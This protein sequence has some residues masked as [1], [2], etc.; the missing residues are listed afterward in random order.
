MKVLLALAMGFHLTMGNLALVGFA[1]TVPT[2]RAR[3]IETTAAIMTSLSSEN[4]PMST[5]MTPALPTIPEIQSVQKRQEGES[6]LAC[7]DVQ[8]SAMQAL[9][10]RST[11]PTD[12][13]I[14]TQ[15]DGGPP[16]ET[17]LAFRSPTAP[18]PLAMLE[19]DIVPE[20]VPPSSGN[21]R[22]AWSSP[23]FVFL[24]VTVV[25]RV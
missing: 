9:G 2:A 14:A 17:S 5:A 25:L 6:I 20:F 24:L 22:A 10:S 19:G 8:Q 4:I 11:C 12:R 3:D 13:C 23:P 18:D 7:A 15:D 1:F 21:N 16:A